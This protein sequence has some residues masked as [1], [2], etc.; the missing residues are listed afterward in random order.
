MKLFSRGN[1]DQKEIDL[2]GMSASMMLSQRDA[3]TAMEADAF[4]L[5][6]ET[7]ADT[8]TQKRLCRDCMELTSDPIGADTDALTVEVTLLTTGAMAGVLWL[9]IASG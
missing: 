3:S 4:N 1:N 6:V 9:A 5:N 8:N 7:N 2:E